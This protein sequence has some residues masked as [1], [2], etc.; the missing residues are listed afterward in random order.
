MEFG[1]D[2]GKRHLDKVADFNL[3]NKFSCERGW[4][5][6][7]M[8]EIENAEKNIEFQVARIFIET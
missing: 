2:K 3:Y 8:Q 6:I 5:R 1:C 4:K 7:L